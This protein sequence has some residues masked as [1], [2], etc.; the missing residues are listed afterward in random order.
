MAEHRLL[1]SIRTLPEDILVAGGTSSRH[2]IAHGA[3]REAVHF[4]VV[5]DQLC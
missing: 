3:G 1:P 4:A 2:Q 5:M